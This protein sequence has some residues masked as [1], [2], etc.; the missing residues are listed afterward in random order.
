M[1]DEL[2]LRMSALQKLNDA[3]SELQLLKTV[4]YGSEHT[5]RTRHLQITISDLEK[6]L[7][8]YYF[9]LIA[10]RQI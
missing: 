10:G 4:V 8:Y 9:Y 2:E 5:E 1:F 6:I 3:F 7:A